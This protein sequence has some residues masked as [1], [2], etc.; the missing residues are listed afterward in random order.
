M[1][2]SGR[3]GTRERRQVWGRKRGRLLDFTALGDGESRLHIKFWLWV[4]LGERA[5]GEVK[6]TTI[7]NRKEWGVDDEK[8]VELE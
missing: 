2:L 1:S 4:L 7:E 3:S 5:L 6:E 8:E